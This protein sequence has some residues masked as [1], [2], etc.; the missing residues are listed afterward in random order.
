MA[1]TPTFEVYELLD[2]VSKGEVPALRELWPHLF[3]T[4]F[5]ASRPVQDIINDVAERINEHTGEDKDT[6]AQ[7]RK[8]EL[9]RQMLDNAL[10]IGKVLADILD[11]RTS[12]RSE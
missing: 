8:A 9:E 10:A 6:S 1:F 5:D 12:K 4:P 7:D 2:R 11:E 3:S